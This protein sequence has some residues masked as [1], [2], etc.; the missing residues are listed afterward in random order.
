MYGLLDD[1]AR[2]RVLEYLANLGADIFD[3][4]MQSA[5]D[6]LGLIRGDPM[7][8]LQFYRM[9]PA[10]MWAEQQQKFPRDFAEDMADFMR[11]EQKQLEPA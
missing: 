6:S 1:A 11:L 8:R 2:K 10:Q 7:Q 5:M 9:K 4:I 3:S